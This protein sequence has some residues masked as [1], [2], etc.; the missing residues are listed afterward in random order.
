MRFEGEITFEDII[1]Y[2]PGPQRTQRSRSAGSVCS[3]E[4]LWGDRDAFWSDVCR[5]LSEADAQNR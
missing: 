4:E 3:E 1:A 5:L 2:Q